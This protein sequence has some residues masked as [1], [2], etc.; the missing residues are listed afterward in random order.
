[1]RTEFVRANSGVLAPL[2][3]R[4]LAWL[5][6][7]LPDTV[8]PDHL[9]AIGL[10]GAILASFG[11]AFSTDHLVLLWLANGGLL[12]NW[13][14]DSLDGHLARLRKCE[15]LRYGFF[16]DQSV[17][18]IAQALFALG[19]GLSGYIH[20]TI[21]A[22]GFGAYLMM[23]IQSLLK[24]QASG[25]FK[26]ATAGIGLTEVRCLLFITNVVF[27]ALPPGPFPS[28]AD[29]AGLIWI[30]TNVFLYLVAMVVELRHLSTRDR[31]PEP[32]SR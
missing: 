25:V 2:E 24:A 30:A 5:A 8:M 16:L 29:L 27:Y 32:L 10:L 19:L 18:V 12:V 9:T 4:A 28:Y 3:R 17:D 26:L 15:R 20:P 11:Y 7:R 21:V 23:S 31:Q 14:G 1:M 22:T 6:V 13:F